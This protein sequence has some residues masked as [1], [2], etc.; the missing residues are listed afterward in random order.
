[1]IED[2]DP[3]EGG[4]ITLTAPTTDPQREIAIAIEIGGEPANL[5]FNESISL[6]LKG[7][8]DL[9]LLER[10][11]HEVVGRHEALRSTFVAGGETFCVDERVRCTVNREDLRALSDGERQARVAAVRAEEVQTPFDL[12]RGP[13]FRTRLLLLQP[14]H[15]ELVFTAHHMV[16]DGYSAGVV[17]S[18]LCEIYNALRAGTAPH[19]SPPPAFSDYANA[20]YAQARGADAMEAE[21]YWFDLLS[22]S[23]PVLDLP[24]DRPRP[25]VRTYDA[26]RHDHLLDFELLSGL[27][28]VARTLGASL[29]S[30]LLAGLDSLLH[31][32]TL[33]CEFMVGMPG[34]GQ[35]QPG[36]EGLVGHCVNTLPVRIQLDPESPFHEHVTHTKGRILD[37]FE[38]QC[39]SF[40]SLLQ[41]LDIPRSPSLVPLIPLLF[42]VDPKL[43]LQSFDGAAA[44]LH[45]NPRAYDAFEL[46]INVTETDDGLVVEATYNTNLFDLETIQAWLDSLEVLL[47]AVVQDPS[48][49]IA[50]LPVLTDPRRDQLLIEWNAT[51]YPLPPV[52]SV[53][54]L[55]E[56]QVAK[57][58]HAIAVRDERVSLTYQ[59]LDER[60]NHVAARLLEF[61]V[62]AEEMI[63]ICVERGADMLVALLGT[64][65][66]GAA[67]VPLDPDYPSS[68]LNQ[69]AEDVQLRVLITQRSLQQL[70]PGNSPNICTKKLFIDEERTRLRQSPERSDARNHLAYVLHTSG[71]TGKPKGVQIEHG[72]LINFLVSMAC[73]PGLKTEDVLVAVT[74]LSFDIA[75]LE[76]YLPL[77]QGAQTVV[78]SKQVAMDATALSRVL[79]QTAATV[80][81]ATPAT[82]RLLVNHGW[83]G[84]TGFKALCGGETLP[85]DLAD[86]LKSRTTELWNLYGPTETTVWSTIARL[87]QPEEPLSIGRPIANTKVYV[88]DAHRQ[89]VPTGAPGELWIGGLGV[90]RGY[91][92]GKEH[93]Q[94]ELNATRFIRNPFDTQGWVYRT[95]DMVRYDSRGRLYFQKREDAQV[96]IRGFRIELGEIETALS[97]HKDIQQSAAMVHHFSEEDARLVAYIVLKETH[98]PEDGGPSMEML[99][100]HL[101]SILPPYMVPQHFVRLPSL[102]L[103]PN[104][105]L[106]RLALPSPDAGEVL[107]SEKYV[108]PATR[109]ECELAAIWM[110]LLRVPRIG[111][112]DNFFSAGGHS[113][114][115]ARMVA[116]VR[117]QMGLELNLRSVF[118]AQTLADLATYIDAIMIS[119][120][121]PAEKSSQ[122]EEMEF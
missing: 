109:T 95:G 120:L 19:L 88:V 71:S 114:L 85:Q 118:Q 26:A 42:N 121:K 67:Y 37:A 16:C 18:E 29:S 96:K 72:N 12:A 3:F 30:L 87:D 2:F 35:I 53:T 52:S 94:A 61:G 47:R 51:Q 107:D 56:Q 31:R 5:A 74:T 75:G 8:L 36:Y 84:P 45:V 97:T 41:K 90:A 40:G 70:S 105:K 48:I 83:R 102:P 119:S 34:A 122:M 86:E 11:W 62:L 100:E 7:P 63:G 103:T 25:L 80:M 115:A 58:P 9:N 101:A 27:R 68:R 79:Q 28:N 23:P 73:E 93:E 14:E 99:R 98:S 81:Q 64:W 116:R 112:R 44:R 60:A 24:T 33:Q 59:E 65:K 38:H 22:P 10:T 117:E 91:Y 111:K 77:V 57:N 20:L 66:A 1:M 55:I 6:E 110:E 50:R 89:P 17:L 106:D 46:Y 78:V 104:G 92:E 13:L 49:P 32:L 54:Q 76:L 43:Q 108:R 39:L 69:I 113:M 15:C 4:E 21:R 82:W